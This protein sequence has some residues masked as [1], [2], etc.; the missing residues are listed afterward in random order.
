MKAKSSKLVTYQNLNQAEQRNKLLDCLKNCPIPDDEILSNIGLFL[1]PQTLSRVLFHNFLYTQIH[2]VQGI[3]IEFG[4]RWGQNLAIYSALRGIYEPFN[5]LRKIVG[6][7]TFDGFMNISEKDGGNQALTEKN[8][9]VSKNYEEY[10]TSIMDFLEYESPLA[11]VRKFEIIKGDAVVELEKYLQLHPETIVALAYFDMDLYEPTLKCLK[12]IKNH[13]TRGSII[14][15]DELNEPAFPGE[16]IAL[17][18]VFGLDRY[19]IKRYAYNS[20]AS[21]IAID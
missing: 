14:G 12:L 10:L 7:D 20:R 15:F 1:N 13:I 21:Y 11:N 19:P 2:E 9:S 3:I 8:Y 18:E 4:C 16:T 17:S 6:F 5:R